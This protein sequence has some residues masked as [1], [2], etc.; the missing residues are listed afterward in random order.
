MIQLIELPTNDYR[1]WAHGLKRAGYATNPKYPQ[2]LIKIIEQYRLYEID[3]EGLDMVVQGNDPVELE[4]LEKRQSGKDKVISVGA[5][6]AYPEKYHNSVRTVIAYGGD[7]PAS[8]SEQVGVKAKRIVKYNESIGSVYET[9]EKG[10]I[11]YL[12]P[13]RGKYK[14]AQEYHLVREGET[15]LNIADKYGIKV[16]KLYSKNG[17]LPGL[18]PAPGQ[19]LTLKRKNKRK[20]KVLSH[21]HERAQSSGGGEYL[22]ELTPKSAPTP[23]ERTEVKQQVRDLATYVV[24][25]S[26]TLYGIARRHGVSVSA[27]KKLNNLRSDTIH[28]GQILKL[29]E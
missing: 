5:K 13:K 10:Q 4:R 16:A 17:V 20:V 25:S 28:P 18:Q 19:K 24:Q 1:A 27:L 12:Q 29:E 23:R 15:M 7:T 11:I 6:R 26:D 21:A 14:G 8:I 9:F 22:D 3:D 2:L